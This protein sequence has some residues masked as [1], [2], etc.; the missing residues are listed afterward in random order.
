M[1]YMICLAELWTIYSIEPT[2]QPG[3]GERPNGTVRG[4][5]GRALTLLPF[6]F[7]LLRQYFTPDLLEMLRAHCS[8]LMRWQNPD[9]FLVLPSESSN[10]VL[11]ACWGFGY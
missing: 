2:K 3:R 5:T 10:I 4:C 1:I 6:S 8:R 7:F 11:E 9:N